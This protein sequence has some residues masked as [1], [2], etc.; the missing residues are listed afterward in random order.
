MPR[1]KAMPGADTILASVR[2]TL[3]QE[4]GGDSLGFRLTVHAEAFETETGKLNGKPK[5]HYSVAITHR[6]LDDWSAEV[7]CNDVS[8][9]LD[10]LVK[11]HLAPRCKMALLGEPAVAP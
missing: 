10:I 5:T 11:E 6:D 9:L 4:L 3:I 2:G 8:T 1:R 7:G